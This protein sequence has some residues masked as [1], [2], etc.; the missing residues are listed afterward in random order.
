MNLNKPAFWDSKKKIFYAILL[1]PLAVIYFFIV[2]LRK[3]IIKKKKFNIKI[4]CVGNIYLGG[5][6]KTPLSIKLAQIL[7]KQFNVAVIKKNYLNQ[8]DEI[9]LLKKYCTV[10]TDKSREVAIQKAIDEKYNLLILDDGFQDTGIIKDLSIICFSSVQGVGNEFLLPS[11]PLRDTLSS[12]KNANIA[13]INGDLNLDLENIIKK[14]NNQIKIFYSR[15]EITN[16]NKYN[17]KNYFIFSGIGNNINF[18]QLLK[19]NN[20]SVNEYKFFPDHY[21]YKDYEIDNLKA[22]AVK[23]NLTLLTTEKDFLRLTTN[24]Q[25]NIEFLTTELI[26]NDEEKLVKELVAV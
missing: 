19:K 22:A 8:Q 20:I 5:T 14:N 10:I 23:K 18:L 26:I 24:Q 17:N 3:K 12:L 1:L 11:G 2:S 6:G 9:S 4:I 25:D 16:I 21:I 7:K 13:L 15:Y